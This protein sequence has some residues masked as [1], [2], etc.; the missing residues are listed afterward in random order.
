MRA[1]STSTTLWRRRLACVPLVLTMAGF[2]GAQPVGTAF[3]HQGRL[4]DGGT[5]ANGPY[6]FRCILYDAAAGGSQ[7]GPIVALEDVSVGGGLFTIALDFG[8]SAFRGQ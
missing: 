1:R 4:T 6:D 3:T 5:P 8:A 2:A 7:V